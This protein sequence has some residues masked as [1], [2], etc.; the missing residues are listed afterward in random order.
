MVQQFSRRL[1]PT[2]F[3]GLDDL[4]VI[5]VGDMKTQE[6]DELVD[7]IAGKQWERFQEALKP[8]CKQYV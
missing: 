6:L 7:I 2:L 8:V 4:T 3:N 1:V 5:A